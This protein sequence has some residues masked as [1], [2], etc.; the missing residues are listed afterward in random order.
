[1][2]LRNFYNILALTTTGDNPIGTSSSWG[3][4]SLNLKQL[5]GAIKTCLNAFTNLSYWYMYNVFPTIYMSYGKECILFGTDD[6]PVTFND[7]TL[8]GY[9]SLSH[10]TNPTWDGVQY[11]ADTK[12]YSNIL[13]ATIKNNTGADF[14]IKEIGIKTYGYDILMYREV[15]ETPITIPAG[16]TIT[17]THEF[18]F[19][20]PQ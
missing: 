15:L 1:M 7:Y 5:N 3:D 6:T 9:K 8:S 2:L 4:G 19:A 13:R 17:Y 20:M 18:K 12:E 14:T 10:T 11:N 16:K